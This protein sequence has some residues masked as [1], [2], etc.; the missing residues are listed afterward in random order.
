MHDAATDETR[1]VQDWLTANC[2]GDHY[3]RGG[4]DLRTRELLTLVLLLLAVLSQLVP[5]IGYPRTLNGLAAINEWRRSSRPETST[6]AR[7]DGDPTGRFRESPS[8]ITARWGLPREPA[9][10]SD[11]GGR[12]SE[13]DT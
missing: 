9:A 2:F 13:M 3:T 10:G 1:W 6:C 8:R 7:Q 5:Y 12:F 4:I 11:S